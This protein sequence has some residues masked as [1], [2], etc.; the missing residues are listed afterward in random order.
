M[1]LIKLMFKEWVVLTILL[2]V[3]LAV[4]ILEGMGIAVF[5]PILQSQDAM[6]VGALPKFFRVPFEF[7]SHYSLGDKIRIISV[8]LLAVNLLRLGFIYIDINLSVFVRTKVL[9]HYK[10]ECMKQMMKMNMGFYNHRR[11]SDFQL[12]FKNRIESHIGMIIEVLCNALPAVLTS[13]I[14]VVL[15]VMSSW[16]ISLILLVSLGI[17]GFL[18]ELLAR[19]VRKS[20]SQ[21]IKTEASF[22]KILFDII[23]GMKIIRTF[24]AQNLML[25][26]FQGEVKELI[27]SYNRMSVITKLVGPF[28][29]VCGVL[30]IC[31]ILICGTMLFDGHNSSKILLTLFT[32]VLILARLIPAL[33]QINH[34]WG[35]IA[36]RLSGLKEADQFLM[37]EETE[38]LQNGQI[39]FSDL[40]DSIEF[41]DVTFSYDLKDKVV[42]DH[43]SFTIKKGQRVG[44]IGASGSGKSTLT[45]LLLRFYDPQTGG[46][47]VDGVNLQELDILSFR[48][49][50]GVVPQ[51]VFLFNETVKGNIGFS[52]PQATDM[53][54]K[55][56]AL[57]ANAHEFIKNLPAGYSTNIGERGVLLSG[58][59]RQRIVI[60]RAILRDPQIL[61]FDEAT[62]ALDTNSERLVQQS[63]NNIAKGKTVIIIAHRLSTVADCDQIIVLERGKIIEKGLR[64]ELL[65]KDSVYKGLVNE[66]SIVI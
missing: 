56:A 41:K 28:F 10:M 17:S 57:R 13:I 30:I 9:T 14:L 19:L 23:N 34:A 64:E 59:Q 55:D 12:L 37:T 2:F 39:V 21:Y 51:D 35:T 53:E 29:E 26:N 18:L 32:F 61:I 3:G 27:K 6:N 5:L 58:G 22:N 65:S 50:I 66:Q 43:V 38:S 8:L 48:N 62:S 1:R 7:L 31:V 33:K 63:L 40:S 4:G 47:W 16:K 20:G 24:N 49:H 25:Q 15:L 46:I 44:I 45:E 42:L 36:A 11:L 60:A 54:I 52:K